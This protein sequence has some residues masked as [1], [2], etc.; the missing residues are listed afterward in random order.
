MVAVR[1]TRYP[2]LIVFDLGVKFVDG[3]AEVTDKKT[4]EALAGIEGVEVPDRPRALT[5]AEKA[6]AKKE[7]EA[8]A[9][10][11]A[12]A[13]KAA[14]EEWLAAEAAWTAEQAATPEEK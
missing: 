7:A 6:K 14:L 3:V 8:E 5:A 2:Q 1:S 11:K 10:A 4:L 9:I 12:E 13:D